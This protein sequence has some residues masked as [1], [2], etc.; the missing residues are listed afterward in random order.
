MCVCKYAC[1]K[2]NVSEAQS[3]VYYVFSIWC[4]VEEKEFSIFKNIGHIYLYQIR[5]FNLSKKLNEIIDFAL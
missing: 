2:T 1:K 3:Y 4:A 5:M